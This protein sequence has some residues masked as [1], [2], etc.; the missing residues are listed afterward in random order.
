MKHPLA[1]RK[2]WTALVCGIFRLI[3]AR[4]RESWTTSYLNSLLFR[5]TQGRLTATAL[6]TSNCD[7]R[8][9]MFRSQSRRRI[10]FT[11]VIWQLGRFHDKVQWGAIK[12]RALLKCCLTR[13]QKPC[14]QLRQ[15]KSFGELKLSSRECLCWA[16]IL[17]SAAGRKKFQIFTRSDEERKARSS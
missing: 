15:T 11:N 3:L 1:R 9:L 6:E 14:V 10:A 17:V 2:L 13:R 16:Q 4:H 5:P 7:R 8:E 12:P